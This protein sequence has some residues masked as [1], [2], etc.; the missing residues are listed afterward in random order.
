VLEH[1]GPEVTWLPETGMPEDLMAESGR[2]L[3]LAEAAVH[4]LHHEFVDG[5]NVW[6]LVRLR[7][8]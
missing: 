1:S 2:G 6:T 8:A 5:Q 4:E 3:A 7:D